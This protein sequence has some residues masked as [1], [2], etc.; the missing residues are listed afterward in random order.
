MF[1][2]GIHCIERCDSLALEGN[3]KNTFLTAVSAA[4]LIVVSGCGGNGP[5]PFNPFAGSYG[6]T[7]EVASSGATGTMTL[8]VRNDGQ[9]TGALT[10]STRG[11]TDG[12]IEVK[13]LEDGTISGVTRYPTEQAIVVTGTVSHDY[14]GGI[15][16]EVK[17]HTGGIGEQMSIKLNRS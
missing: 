17:R 6:G 3:M 5:D 9:G 14:K 8:V 10:D 16:G 15:V 12:T 11:F 2:G 4:V 7:W 1:S 13:I